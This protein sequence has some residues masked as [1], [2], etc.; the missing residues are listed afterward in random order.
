MEKNKSINIQDVFLNHVR[1]E[2][3][4]VTIF[5]TNGVPIRG[6]VKG[7]D[8]FTVVLEVEGRQQMIYKHAISTIAPLKPVSFLF[9][10]N[11]DDSADNAA[12]EAVSER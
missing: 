10:D 11:S 12:D 8:S 7:F 3:I 2:N 1:K 5:I 4:A 6:F 9:N